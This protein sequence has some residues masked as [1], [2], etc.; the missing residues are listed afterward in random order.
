MLQNAGLL[1]YLLLIAMMPLAACHTKPESKPVLQWSEYA[2]LPDTGNRPSLGYAGPVTGIISNMLVIAGGAN[3]PDDMPWE[4]GKKQYYN[5]AYITAI[6]ASFPSFQKFTLP[7]KAA[8][9]ANC[10]TVQGIVCAGGENEQGPLNKVLLLQWINDQLQVT[11]LPY[12][13]EAITNA[14]A[15]AIGSK[16]FVAGGE[17]PSAALA[18]LH[19]LDLA[20]TSKGWQPLKNIPHAVSHTVLVATKDGKHIYLSGGRKKNSNGVSDLYNK[21]YEYDVADNR[22]TEKAPLPY[23]LSAG[24]ST[25]V[26]DHYIAMFGGDKGAT[27]HQTEVLISN[28]KNE[29]DSVKKQQ[30]V[31]EKIKLQSGHP[32]FSNE[33]WL[34]D[35]KNDS[36]TTGGNIPFAVP[37]TTTAVKK[38][39]RIWIPSGEIKAGVRTPQ[40]LSGEIK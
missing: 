2:V 31:A 3:F 15:V 29:T 25:I 11:P 10:S 26:N 33:I 23:A 13:P 1:Y 5:E 14:A 38:E 37:V 22:W 12:L 20:D 16:V 9:S 36:W 27:F 39:N 24:T 40:I 8:Y 18:G 6:D 28:I 30:L 21:V 34:Y 17:T 7:Y 4:G 19:V 32:G 35:I